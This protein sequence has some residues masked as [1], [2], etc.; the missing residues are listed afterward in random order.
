MLIPS[1]PEYAEKWLRWREEPR[2]QQFNPLLESS[3]ADLRDRLSRASSDLSN[4]RAAEEFLFF[5]QESGE[6]VGQVKLSGV[7]HTMGYGEIGYSIAESHQGR[8]IGTLA[9][10]TLVEKVFRETSLRRLFAFVAVEN[11]ASCRLLERVGFR[12][13][14][15]CREHFLIRGVPTDEAIHG[16]LRS[17]LALSKQT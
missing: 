16:L 15:V 2:S 17:D 8:G 14:G 3:V 4:L 11:T 13:E 10:Q 7:N 5:W 12:R 1:S 6:I 9:V